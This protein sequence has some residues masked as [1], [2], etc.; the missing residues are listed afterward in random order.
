MARKKKDPSTALVPADLEAQLAPGRQ[1]AEQALQVIQKMNLSTQ[2]NRDRAG[3]VLKQIRERIA[4]IEEQRK[5]L[6][7]PLL[8]A[9]RR[10]DSLHNVNKDYWQA[11]NAALSERLLA[12]TQE[13]EA[14]QRAALALVSEAGGNVDHSVL[15]VAH[16]TPKTP[17]GLQER[18][19]KDYRV[20]NEMA[21][22]DE[23]WCLDH[24]K[25]KAAVKAEISVPGVEVFEVKSFAKGRS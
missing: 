10:I 1:E 8:E 11:C 9:K 24:A 16:A 4:A 2:P 18:V 19:S 5:H 23:Y 3:L 14:E 7:A 6:T 17:E 15:A 25:I 22:P 13:A 21:V 20:V 12:A